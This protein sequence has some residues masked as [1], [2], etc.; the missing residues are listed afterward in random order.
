MAFR[1]FLFVLCMLFVPQ[2]YAAFPP[3]RETPNGNYFHCFYTESNVNTEN[4]HAV[5]GGIVCE[6]KDRVCYFF[7][8]PKP[9][10]A[11]CERK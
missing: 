10:L 5:S 8:I 11:Y 6:S 2:V 7:D 1:V 3:G 9:V 4:I